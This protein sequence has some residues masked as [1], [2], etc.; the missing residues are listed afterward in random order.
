MAKFCTKCGAPLVDG[1]CPMCDKEVDTSPKW[2]ATEEEKVTAVHENYIHAILNMIKRPVTGM[3]ESVA[4]ADSKVGLIMMALEALTSGKQWNQQPRIVQEVLH[5][6]SF[7]PEIK[8]LVK[9]IMIESYIE[10]GNQSIG[11]GI[12]GKSITDPCLGWDKSSALLY[13]MADTV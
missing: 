8:S 4:D 5:S 13:R 1:K 7:L 11:N 10:D 6:R 3:R 12:Y 2:T 9:G